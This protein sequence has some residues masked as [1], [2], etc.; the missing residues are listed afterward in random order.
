M[1]VFVCVC[2]C[3]A[4]TSC[5]TFGNPMDCSPQA[6][7]FHGVSKARILEWVSISSSRGSS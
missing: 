3:L 6:P 1:C 2:V 7:P 4:A 5:L